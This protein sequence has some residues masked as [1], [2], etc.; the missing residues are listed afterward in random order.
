[1]KW[2][3]KMSMKILA[4]IKKCLILVTKYY[5]NSNTLVIG[6]MKDETAEVVIEEFVTLKPKMYSYLHN[7]KHKKAKGVNRNV[8]ATIS[9]SK[10]KDVLLNKKCLRHSMNRIQSKDHKIGTHEI[11][12]ISLSYL[13]NKIYIQNNRW[14]GLALSY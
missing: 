7:S 13:D 14:D 1:M 5:D 3:L 8:V 6:K 10:Y 2:K 12:K 4:M 9:H 11:N